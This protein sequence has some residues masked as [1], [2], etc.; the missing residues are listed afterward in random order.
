MTRATVRGRDLPDPPVL[1]I[2]DSRQAG[3]PLSGLALRL[4]EAGC[5]WFLVREKH[6]HEDQQIELTSK[7]VELA[8]PFGATVLVSGSTGVCRAAGAHGVHLP[9]SGDPLA[10]RSELG[11]D[12]LVGYSAHSHAKLDLAHTAGVDYATYSPIFASPSKPGY[13]P[14]LG[15]PELSRT[16]AAHPLPIVALGGVDARTAQACMLHGAA[17]VAV[18]G[19]IMRAGNPEAVFGRILAAIDAGRKA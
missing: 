8:K 2:S 19:E 14:T 18:M 4:F 5:R 1:V 7:I 16:S 12:A 6:L 11:R 17:G 3:R 15:L 10:A 9:A 13:G